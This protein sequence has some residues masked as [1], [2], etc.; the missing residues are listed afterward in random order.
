M[1]ERRK[2]RDSRQTSKSGN[3]CDRV[4]RREGKVMQMITIIVQGESNRVTS[5]QGSDRTRVNGF[6]RL[7]GSR[8]SRPTMNKF[9]EQIYI[10]LL[11]IIALTTTTGTA[12]SVADIT[13]MLH[14]C[15]Q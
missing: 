8:I 13:V 10:Q 3:Q 14:I 1:I 15:A 6:G 5:F 11:A 12:N 7:E 9:L 4:W 2:R